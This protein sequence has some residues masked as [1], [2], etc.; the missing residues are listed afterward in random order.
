LI[1]AKLNV[2]MPCESELQ[3]GENDPSRRF[4]NLKA[5]FYQALADA[6]EHDQ[7]E[8]LTGETT[9][10]QFAGLLT[11]IDSHGRM[12]IESKEDARKR[13]VPSPDR[14]EALML[15]LCKPPQKM[16]FYSVHDLPRSRTGLREDPDDPRLPVSQRVQILGRLREGSLAW[17]LR[18]GGY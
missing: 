1:V 9:I 13:G 4:P 18:R 11:E 2:G 7:I 15:A 8:G 14:A 6:F 12:K 17:Q 5:S 16:E 10:G 3:L